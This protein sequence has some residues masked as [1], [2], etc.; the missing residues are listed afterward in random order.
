MKKNRFLHVLKIAAIA[1]IG[2]SLLGTAVA[3]IW[4]WIIPDLFGWHAITFWRALG[5]LFLCRVL[6]GGFRSRPGSGGGPWG[7]RMME[8]WERMTP[9]ERETVRQGMRGKCGKSDNPGPSQ[10]ETHG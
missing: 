5:L 7:R 3:Q 4:N 10:V 2:I 9:E 8:R 6:F 1:T